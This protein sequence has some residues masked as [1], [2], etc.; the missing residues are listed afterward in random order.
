MLYYKNLPRELLQ[1][2]KFIDAH[3]LLKG[4]YGHNWIIIPTTNFLTSEGIEWFTNKKIFLRNTVKVF[5]I[6]KNFKGPVHSDAYGP[7]DVEY[8][9]N[10]VISGQGEMQWVDNI[11]GTQKISNTNNS[12]YTIYTDVKSLD[13]I[14]TWNGDLGI[15][16]VNV[17][18]RV[19]TTNEERYCVSVRTIIGSYPKTFEDAVN[20]I[21]N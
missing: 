14:D 2:V 8:A 17:P 11:Q 16:R 19:V 4:I 9:F 7:F 10:F 13:I 5:K 15:V 12:L 1:F 6:E 3:N 21:Y 20:I 18:H